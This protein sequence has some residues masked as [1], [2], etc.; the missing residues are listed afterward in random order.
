[1]LPEQERAG[2]GGHLLTL[3]RK[4]FIR[5]DRSLFPGDDGFR[6][7]HILIRDAAYDSM[8]KRVRAELHER[9][10]DWLAAK[11]GEDA[12][13]EILGY[14]LEQAYRYRI[15]LGRDDEHTQELALR[16]GG[17]LAE[18]GRRADAR[19]DAA[20]ARTLLERATSLLPDTDPEV[21]ALLATLAEALLDAGDFRRAEEIA[22]GA[23]A[24]AAAT[25]E[26][27]V[28]LR[29]R[30]T[31]L[32]VTTYGDPGDDTDAIL[33]E[34]E[35]AIAELEQLGDHESLVR[36]AYLVTVVGAMRSDFALIER[37]SAQ[38]LEMA[39]RAGIRR[40]AL[41]AAV[42]LT[43]ALAEGPTPVDEAIPRA[44]SVLANFP[45]EHSGEFHLAVLYALAGRH[46][47]AKVT[48]ERARR[49][50]LELGQVTMHASMSM[51]AAWIAQLAGEPARAED[52]LRAGAEVL[53]EAGERGTLSTVAATLADVLYELGSDD[54]ALEWAHR[55][56]QACHPEDTLSHAM[57]RSARAKVLAR[58]GEREEALRLSTEAVDWARKSDGV[59]FLANTLTARAEVLRLG[60][61]DQQA[62]AAL[63]EALALYEHKGVVPAIERTRALLDPI[64]AE[65]ADA[66][67]REDDPSDIATRPT[68]R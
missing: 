2:V 38:R 46:D 32:A 5:P 33:A 18:A 42:W 67:S 30:M 64:P 41:W 14:H 3:A 12:S 34:A 44:E 28:E 45:G 35:R 36:A 49:A 4:E 7:G 54:E 60:G 63:E 39:L 27:S 16:A 17:V 59:V 1:L 43:L 25:G 26:R 15:E 56:Q 66:A 40:S 9:F 10:A 29:A 22:R 50:L 58:R 57:W 55:S 13:D 65:T 52:D 31:E 62:R 68:K 51:N 24:A 21:P 48:I 8:P 53:D 23:Q 19:L 37:A 20:A 61:S 11:L 6:F 47:E